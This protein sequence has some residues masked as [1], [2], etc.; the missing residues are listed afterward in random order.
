MLGIERKTT[1]VV[2]LMLLMNLAS[3]TLTAH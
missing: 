1:E 2:L 3:I